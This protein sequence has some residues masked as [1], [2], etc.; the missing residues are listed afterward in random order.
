M[1]RRQFL[2][3]T[4]TVAAGAG[5]A[6][7]IG[8]VDTLPGE[9]YP[10]I[11]EWLTETEVGDADDTYDGTIV[12]QRGKDT[13]RV[14]VGVGGNG[15]EYA[16]GPS[17]VAVTPGT[18]VRWVWT[19][20]G[21]E[22]SV[23]ADPE[24]QIGKSDYEFASGKLVGE[25]GHEYTRTFDEAGIALYHCDGITGMSGSMTGRP[26]YELAAVPVEPGRRS[27]QSFETTGDAALHFDPH[28]SLGMKGGVA[29]AE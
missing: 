22:H 11:D 5:L 29:V 8:G 1:R 16:F 10:A 4:G 14:D 17:A 15:G 23:V 7:C 26:D 6:G 9:E 20:D 2:W 27:G 3:A 13:V 19:G 21:G 28:L 25:A 24:S 12:D 18:T